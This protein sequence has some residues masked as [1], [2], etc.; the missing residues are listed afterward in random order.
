MT[1]YTRIMELDLPKG[2]SAFLWG[3]RSTGKSTFLKQKYPE[4][5]YYDLLNTDVLNKLRIRP[6]ILREE[7]SLQPEEHLQYPI[8]IDE[9]QK[10]PQLLDEVHWLIE[11]KG[12]SFILCGSSARKLKRGAANLLGGRAWKF[13]FYPLTFAEVDDFD[14]LRALNQGLIPSIYQSNYPKRAFRAYVDLYLKEEI[15]VEGLVRNLPAFARFLDLVGF[16]NTELLNYKKIATDCGIDAKTVKEYYNILLDTLI[17]YYV[18]P[19]SKN[20][21]RQVISS[22]PKFY[23]FDVGVGCYLSKQPVLEL[24]GTAAGNAFEHYIFMELMAYIGLKELEYKIHY[25]R[26]KTGH[27]VDFITEDGDVAIEVKISDN[28]RKTDYKGLLTFCSDHKPRLAIVVCLVGEARKTSDD[29][30]ILP[31]KKFLN[32]LWAG[33]IIK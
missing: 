30:L 12:L 3:A 15:Q 4:S 5:L 28:P 19:F 14:L 18:Y 25:W 11:N 10:V 33:K 21:K 7:L 24:R 6:A 23:L 8:I 29:I 16:S 31:W 20:E 1:Q 9:V 17:G 32:D 2:Q 27:E 22:T 13:T 26:T